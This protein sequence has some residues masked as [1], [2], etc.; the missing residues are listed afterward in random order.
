MKEE[1]VKSYCKGDKVTMV[2]RGGNKARRFLEVLV[3]AEG[4]C[5]GVIWLLKGHFGRGWRRFAGELWHLLVAQIKKT[6]LVELRVPSTA[7]ILL[8]PS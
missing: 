8:K 4:G 6:G 1:I 2:H 7:R 3:F 5:K